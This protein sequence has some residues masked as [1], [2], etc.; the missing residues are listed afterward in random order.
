MR[1]EPRYMRFRPIAL[2]LPALIMAAFALPAMAAADTGG[3]ISAGSGA[4]HGTTTTPDATTGGSGDGAGGVSS[5]TKYTPKHSL[6]A[7]AFR[8]ASTT[9]TAGA[10][11]P[12]ITVEVTQ[13]DVRKVTAY[14][15]FTPPRGHGH[16][17]RVD[18]GSIYT[19]KRFTVTL[20]ASKL[21]KLVAGSYA[22]RLSAVSPQGQLLRRTKISPGR[23]TLNVNAKP[24]A[25]PAPTQSPGEIK[26]ESGGKV[27]TTTKKT[28][29]KKKASAPKTRFPVAGAHTFGDRFGVGR[30]GHKHQGQ[31]VPAAAGTPIVAPT[32]G[33]ITFTGY[34]AAA[35][36]EWV[37]MHSSDGRDF[38]FAHCV[39][40]ST[41]VKEGEAVKPGSHLCNVGS[42]GDASGPHL[43]FEIWIDGWRTSSKS[44]PID[45]LPQLERWQS[46]DKR[47]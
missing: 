10:K 39:R 34:Q 3:G 16:A 15:Q 28:T 31:D 22:L 44:H 47:F 26:P 36:G 14:I 9:V 41:K 45:P 29:T 24:K 30:V 1:A 40:H 12:R 35:A 7:V 38:F 5:G 27:T 43:H 23:A 37:A 46:A 11:V 20:P 13:P 4:T 32:A 2:S 17:V 33:R 25:K 19:G 6:L 42:T 21:P 8:L 18:L